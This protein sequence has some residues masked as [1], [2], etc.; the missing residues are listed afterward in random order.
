VKGFVAPNRPTGWRDNPTVP[1]GSTPRTF[2]HFTSP[3]RVEL[4]RQHGILMGDVPLT[5]TGGFN[6]PW[7]TEDPERGHQRWAAGSCEAKGAVRLTVEVPFPHPLLVRWPD[8]AKREGV[9]PKW[10]ATLDRVGGGGSENWWVF[11]GRIPPEWIV[12]IEDAPL[13]GGSGPSR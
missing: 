7:L 10:Y 11:K 2:Y 12:K 3:D 13:V 5:P 8:L 9:E 6:A 1:P 4:I